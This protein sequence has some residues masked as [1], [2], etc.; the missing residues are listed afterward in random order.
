MA[1]KSERAAAKKKRRGKRSERAKDEELIAGR[2]NWRTMGRGSPDQR[3]RL[4]FRN[5]QLKQQ[6]RRKFRDISPELG[7]QADNHP[8]LKTFPDNK[9]KKEMDKSKSKGGGPI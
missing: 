2:R 5:R 4:L 7:D 9:K 1:R 8:N 3:D 6:I